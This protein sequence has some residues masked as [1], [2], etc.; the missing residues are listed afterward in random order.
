MGDRPRCITHNCLMMVKVE[1]FH[2]S[3]KIKVKLAVPAY[4]AP[5]ELKSDSSFQQEPARVLLAQ[6]QLQ[7]LRRREPVVLA[8]LSHLW[9]YFRWPL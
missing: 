6:A 5:K 9:W 2:Q 1:Q 4:Y 3:P 7:G 8:E